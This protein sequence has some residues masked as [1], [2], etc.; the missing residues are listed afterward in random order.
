MHNSKD[1]DDL[2]R[3]FEDHTLYETVNQEFS[4]FESGKLVLDGRAPPRKLTYGMGCFAERRLE[5]GP[6]TARLGIVKLHDPR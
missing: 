2:R 6:M 5:R 3:D 4:N 1:P